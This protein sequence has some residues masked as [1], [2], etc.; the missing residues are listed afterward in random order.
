MSWVAVGVSAA[1]A[2][3]GIV[4]GKRA[5]KE[6]ERA[7]G[8]AINAQNIAFN[9][10]DELLEPRASQEQS[11]MEQVNRLLGLSGEEPDYSVFRDSPGY[12]FQREQGQQAIE[13][14]AAAR[15]GLQSGNTLAAVTEFGQGLADTT[16]RNYLADVMALQSQGVDAARA[17][18][19]TQRAANVGNLLLGQGEARASGIETG[20][21]SLTNF[22]ENFT[23]I[24]GQSGRMGGK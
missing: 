4:G 9:E 23:G 18:L 8:S 15:G 24:W 7:A 6:R 1:S 14:S 2:I 17:N 11:A 10:A 21:N 22:G 16:F 5:A 13:R 19:T 20:V 12:Q 3:S